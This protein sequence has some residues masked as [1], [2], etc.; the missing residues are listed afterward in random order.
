MKKIHTDSKILSRAM[1]L[2][3]LMVSF[4]SCFA[5][6]SSAVSA[7]D[8]G[9]V[10]TIRLYSLKFSDADVPGITGM[11]GTQYS[12]TLKQEGSKEASVGLRMYY[13]FENGEKY[14]SVKKGE[15]RGDYLEFRLKDYSALKIWVVMFQNWGYGITPINTALDVSVDGSFFEKMEVLKTAPASS[16]YDAN[17]KALY[18]YPDGTVVNEDVELIV[19]ETNAGEIAVYYNNG[20][21]TNELGETLTVSEPMSFAQ[22]SYSE[23][24]ARVAPLSLTDDTQ[25]RYLLT[26]ERKVTSVKVD[27]PVYKVTVQEKKGDEA[28]KILCLLGYKK[29]NIF[30]KVFVKPFDWYMDEE[31]Y[32]LTGNRIDKKAYYSF[33]PERE[34]WKIILASFPI[35]AGT[36]S[37]YL[38]EIIQEGKPFSEEIAIDAS[39]G[40]YLYDDLMNIISKEDGQLKDIGGWPLIASDN[41]PCY[42][43]ENGNYYTYSGK[44]MSVNSSKQLVDGAGYIIHSVIKEIKEGDDLYFRF[45]KDCKTRI[46]GYEKWNSKTGK[47]DFYDMSA[48]LVD[49]DE[50]QPSEIDE[51]DYDKNHPGERE[52][53]QTFL[54]KV[55]AVLYII[56][57]VL[58]SATAAAI[59]IYIIYL[60]VKAIRSSSTDNKTPNKK[61]A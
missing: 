61:R 34:A 1:A 47:F 23:G 56:V 32:D 51:G 10:Y 41:R 39:T 27:K 58:A 18:H 46:P 8:V 57:V 17:D 26:K 16:V 25:H 19:N 22:A 12:I 14:L 59:V 13:N 37:D 45:M 60:V 54:D 28:F 43:D 38:E 2:L 3:L 33:K 20:V 35:S 11:S 15:K 48:K 9:E 49:P 53:E 50:L 21:F 42:Y 5:F 24:G 40:E 52:K 29:L 44:K 4:F 6:R 55:L 7:E 31:W 30:Q 36:I